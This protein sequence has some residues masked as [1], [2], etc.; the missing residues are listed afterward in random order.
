MHL[1][2][3]E[4]KLWGIQMVTS[5]SIFSCE[6]FLFQLVTKATNKATLNKKTDPTRCGSRDQLC[7]LAPTD[8][9]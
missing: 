4:C 3:T 5:N 2:D 9:C 6:N 8:S 1:S 7:T